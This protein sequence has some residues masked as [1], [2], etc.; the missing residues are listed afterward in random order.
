MFIDDGSQT[1]AFE[2]ILAAA[3][4]ALVNEYPLSIEPVTDEFTS[5][6]HH[7]IW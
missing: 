7:C 6:S 1:N 5:Y 3:W 2:S 4:S